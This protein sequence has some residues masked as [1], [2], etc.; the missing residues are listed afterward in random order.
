MRLQA[1][2]DPDFLVILRLHFFQPCSGLFTKTVGSR[3]D[4]NRADFIRGKEGNINLFQRFKRGVRIGKGLKVGDAKTLGPFFA[5]PFQICL[6][7]GLERLAALQNRI[8]ASGR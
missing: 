7:L 2:F 3:S 6:V 1:E 8:A 5:G 4:G